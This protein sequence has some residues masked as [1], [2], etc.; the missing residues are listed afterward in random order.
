MFQSR[1]TD[2]TVPVCGITAAVFRAKHGKIPDRKQN[3]VRKNADSR[4]SSGKKTVL[5][6]RKRSLTVTM[7]T[8]K[9]KAV[10]Q[11]SRMPLRRIAGADRPKKQKSPGTITAAGTLT[12]KAKKRADTAGG[13]IRTGNARKHLISGVISRQRNMISQ[14]KIPLQRVRSRS[15][16][17]AKN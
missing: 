12:T 9:Q 14:K 13:N 11:R 5:R 3:P 8:V 4:G 10:F 16:M 15:F 17:E 6:D 2:R 1:K 7:L